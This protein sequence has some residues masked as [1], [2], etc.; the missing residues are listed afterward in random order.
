MSLGDR[1]LKLF[2][3]EQ[4]HSKEEII[5]AIQQERVLGIINPGEKFA[6]LIFE[7]GKH[8]GLYSD[9][10]SSADENQ[11]GFFKRYHRV[12]F[13]EQSDGRYK[14]DMQYSLTTN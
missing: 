14:V 5:S 6:N 13:K 8:I 11:D 3:D 10:L 4:T 1:V 7:V 12:S 9:E 2:N